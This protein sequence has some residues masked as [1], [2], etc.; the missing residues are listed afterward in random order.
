MTTLAA[1]ELTRPTRWLG[2][3]RS[4]DPDARTAGVLAATEAL[5]AGEG[6]KFLLV[7]SSPSYDL[8]ELTA[9]V[10]AAAD[11][12]PFV[13][14]STSG[15]ISTSG[16]G[17]NTVIVLCLGGPGFEVAVASTTDASDDLRR[18][19]ARAAECMERVGDK[20]H[21]VL[22]LLTDG[23]AGD[24]QEIVRGAYGVVG[25]EVPLVGGCAGD[26]LEMKRTFVFHGEH[27][28]DNAVV[29]VALTSDASLGIGVSHG[30][31]PVGS[32]MLV[33]HSSGTRVLSLDD[34]P[35][36]D[37]YLRVLN[38]PAEAHTD[39]AAF[40]HFAQTHP[41]GISR[42]SGEEVRFV[43]DADFADRSLG[44]IAPVPQGG[45]AWI[46]EGDIQSVLAA[47]DEA[48]ASA[49][50]QLAGLPPLGFVAF[51]C[52]ARRGVLGSEGIKREVDRISQQAGGAPVA[53]FYTYG[54][55]ARTRG[56]AGFHNQ[57]LVVLA[58][59]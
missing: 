1:R 20:G 13:G 2:L 25:A 31:R 29:A 46:M 9:G 6:A 58:L 35:A 21:R 36:L 4:A 14:C 47:T 5:D 10:A 51:D 11:G 19:G 49:L 33:S 17:D 39:Q 32:P 8:Q 53:G 38:A 24:Q 22:L 23:L 42:R 43:A 37:V 50:A 15:E 44:C 3:G 26:N 55:I 12:L 40:T 56:T 41:L 18:A 59:G 54:E 52:I 7:F 27:V 57:T 45:L 16:P 30:W 48:C 34:E 28:M